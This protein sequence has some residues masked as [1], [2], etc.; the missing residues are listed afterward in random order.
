MKSDREVMRRASLLLRAGE[1]IL[2]DSLLNEALARHEPE[3]LTEALIKKAFDATMIKLA[4][5]DMSPLN[6]YQSGVFFA[7]AFYNINDHIN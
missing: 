1:Y 2:A 6:W 7:N 5:R 3:P 4:G